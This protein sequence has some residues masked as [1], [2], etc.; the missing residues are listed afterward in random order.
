MQHR[1]SYKIS[2]NAAD[3]GRIEF[4]ASDLGDGGQM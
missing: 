4:N 1:A 3:I 2:R